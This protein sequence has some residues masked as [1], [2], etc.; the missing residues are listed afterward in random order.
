M[1]ST[2][3]PGAGEADPAA[4]DATGG[5]DADDQA[6]PVDLEEATDDTG[7]VDPPADWDAN[8]HDDEDRGA[9]V[10]VTDDAGAPV[11]GA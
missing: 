1:T 5:T 9:D 7:L 3:T 10:E 2:P 11:E 6:A 8:G 4:V